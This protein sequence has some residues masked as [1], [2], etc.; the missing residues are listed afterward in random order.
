MKQE[1]TKLDKNIKE[2]ALQAK[3]TPPAF[4]KDA[5]FAQLE[6]KE[7]K[8]FTFWKIAAAILLLFISI[9]AFITYK[10]IQ[11]TEE[12][13]ILSNTIV[14][15]IIE[16]IFI[17]TLKRIENNSATPIIEKVVKQ[18]INSTKK[19]IVKTLIEEEKE[20]KPSLITNIETKKEPK[21]KLANNELKITENPKAEIIVI[22]SVIDSNQIVN[23]NSEMVLA[24][25]EEKQSNANVIRSVWDF[26]NLL[27][28]KTAEKSSK[29]LNLSERE[30]K[31]QIKINT[32]LAGVKINSTYTL[33]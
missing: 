2:K 31:R 12:L 27:V 10:P 21:E 18:T 3:V 11:K 22:A 29:W 9:F 16:N 32:T 25:I 28:H 4:L 24:Q 1:L 23:K 33:K 5:I 20:V 30:N 7:E 14:T 15:P 6:Q 13:P 17:D 26:A 8:A 19:Q